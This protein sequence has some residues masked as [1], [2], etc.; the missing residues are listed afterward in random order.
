[1]KRPNAA[2]IFPIVVLGLIAAATWQ[3]VAQ[4]G[5]LGWTIEI[6]LVPVL[7]VDLVLIIKLW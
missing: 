5:P 7:L 6:Q 1:M 2:I 3:A 4:H